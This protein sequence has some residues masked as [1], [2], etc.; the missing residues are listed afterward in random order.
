ME[1]SYMVVATNKPKISV[2]VDQELLEWFQE[3]CKEQK[4][5]MSSQLSFMIEQLKKQE[6]GDS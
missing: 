5:S 1:F 6:K 3:Y 2:Y 4:R